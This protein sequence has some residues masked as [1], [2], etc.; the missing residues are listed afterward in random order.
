MKGK[1][2]HYRMFFVFQDPNCHL[3][4]SSATNNILE[5][6]EDDETEN[7]SD[8]DRN[9]PK[10]DPR[11]NL[12][13]GVRENILNVSTYSEYGAKL[14]DVSFLEYSGKFFLSSP[15]KNFSQKIISRFFRFRSD[16]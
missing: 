14:M 9:G 4:T 15:E 6:I 11:K 16:R 8:F 7:G 10:N 5:A 12:S 1:L 3:F 2:P 13:L